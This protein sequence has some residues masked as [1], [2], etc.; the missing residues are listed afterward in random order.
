MIRFNHRCS[1]AALLALFSLLAPLSMDALQA[2]ST[3]LRHE[4]RRLGLRFQH[5]RQFLVGQPA[6]LPGSREMA[7]AM[8]KKG[9]VYTPSVEEALIERR[10]AAGQDL[11]ALKRGLSQIS[12][13]RCRGSEAE[14]FR[15]FMVKDQFRQEIGVWQVYVLPAAPG[16][17]GE[18]AFYYL[19]PLKD[20][21]V[22]EILAPRSY[23]DSGDREDEPTHYDQVIRRLIESLEIIE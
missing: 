19:V 11:K 2:S 10:L 8:A 18:H 7:E 13:N 17:Y 12:L 1:A 5:P 22:L 20:Q 9:L 15:H 16:P 23:S 6:E 21:S 4:S 3:E 14:F